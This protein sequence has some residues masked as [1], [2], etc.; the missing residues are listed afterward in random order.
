MSQV[1][2][3]QYNLKL[4]ATQYLSKAQLKRTNV[5]EDFMKG[6]WPSISLDTLN[7]SLN[8]TGPQYK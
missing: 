7:L 4:I 6:M 2:A 1:S 5:I 3:G 8:H